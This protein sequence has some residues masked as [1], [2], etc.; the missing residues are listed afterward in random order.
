MTKVL[1]EL[2]TITGIPPQKST[3]QAQSFL[4]RLHGA[5][6]KLE[7]TDWDEGLSDVAQRWYNDSSAS[8][9]GG[10]GY[11]PLDGVHDGHDDSA[12]VEEKPVK[13]AKVKKAKVEQA[14]FDLV[15]AP[16]SKKSK[17]SKKAKATPVEEPAEAPEAR[18]S[19]KATKVTKVKGKKA[20]AGSRGRPKLDDTAVLKRKVKTLPAG[21]RN[22]YWDK[23][24]EGTSMAAIRKKR[25]HLRVVRYWRR[26]GFV[27]LTAA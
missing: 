11:L 21:N 25:A 1:N 8:V 15:D 20:K 26:N 19:K 12:V 6:D 14:E 9:D 4:A 13:P 7:D 23:I 10:A 2:V 24:P 18:K 5:V 27:E 3:E 16:K 17:K 22:D